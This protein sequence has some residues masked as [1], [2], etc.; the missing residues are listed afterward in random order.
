MR[1]PDGRV[2]TA[3]ERARR[4]R[5]RPVACRVTGALTLVGRA[6]RQLAVDAGFWEQRRGYPQPRQV[7]R[8]AG[9]SKWSVTGLAVVAGMFAGAAL[10]RY[11]DRKTADPSSSREWC[12]RSGSGTCSTQDV[13]ASTSARTPSLR[14]PAVPGGSSRPEAG[15]DPAAPMGDDAGSGRIGETPGSPP[16]PP[17]SNADSGALTREG[18]EARVDGLFS[19]GYL[20]LMA[21]IQ[22]AAFG[23]LFL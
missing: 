17:A 23:L 8:M 1:Y 22:G 7:S 14:R 20:T 12:D 2:L 15:T 11:N 9:G 16:I 13:D 18:L 19:V 21:I 3:A 4:E 6:N 5:V 10:T